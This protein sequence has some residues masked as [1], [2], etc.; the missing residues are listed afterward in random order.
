MNGNFQ[1]DKATAEARAQRIRQE[2]ASQ[3]MAMSQTQNTEEPETIV[4]VPQY[5]RSFSISAL[6]MIVGILVLF[7]IATPA[8]AQSLQDR[9]GIGDTYGTAFYIFTMGNV[10]YVRENYEE[11]VAL[12]QESIDMIPTEIFEQVPD[13]AHMYFYLGRSQLAFGMQEDALESF[14]MYI[15]YSQGE[16][17]PE[18]VAYVE[19]QLELAEA[20]ETEES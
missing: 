20:M 7:F 4:L 1:F 9:S 15:D 18:V 6:I 3:Q 11:S 19:A 17:L 8:S 13:Y 5:R 10:A 14:M 16:A 2:S 12:F